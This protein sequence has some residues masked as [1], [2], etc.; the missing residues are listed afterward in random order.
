SVILTIFAY[1]PLISDFFRLDSKIVRDRCRFSWNLEA[2]CLLGSLSHVLIDSL[3]HEYNPLLF[4]FTC[5]SC[6]AL[7]FMNDWVL[8]SMIIPLSFLALL[9][10][11]VVKEVRRGTKNIW[12]R[13]LVK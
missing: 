11:F 2:V 7:V 4:P 5:E 1:P 6:N 13:L 12:L 10:F 3:H 8:A 9:V